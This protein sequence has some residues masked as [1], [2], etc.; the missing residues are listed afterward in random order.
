[1]LIPVRVLTL[2]LLSLLIACSHPPDES[3]DIVFMNAAAFTLNENMPWA[4]A[5]AVRDDRIV[6][7]G[8]NEGVI[9][10]IGNETVH[11]NLSGRMLL[12]GFID[13]HAHPVDA[14]GYAKALSLD[15]YGTIE[16][17]VQAISDYASA[18]PDAPVIFGYGFLASAFGPIGPTRQLIDVV[19]PD[20]PVL[21]MDEGLHAAWA[22][23][24]AL[25]ELNITKDTL[26]PVPG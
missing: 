16:D 13:A 26:D 12:P 11:H 25:E 20:R 14:G 15:T 17:W 18:N 6:Y 4:E 23:S 3:A 5:V 24:R 2:V 21:I 9:E 1:M 8:D 19:V 22:N 7:V 10:F